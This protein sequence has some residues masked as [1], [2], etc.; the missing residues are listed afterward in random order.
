MA[1][2]IT[3][4]GFPNT[5]TSIQVPKVASPKKFIVNFRRPSSY[6]GEYGFDWM[7]DDYITNCE[8]YEKLKD[9]YTPVT[10][11]KNEYFVPWLSMFPNQ[12]NVKLKLEINQIE[13]SPTDIDIIKF[14]SKEGIKFEPN[15]IKVSEAN[16]K[17]ITIIC[18][19]PLS[20]DVAISLLDKDNNEVGKLNVFKNA[21]HD[22]LHFN[23]IPVRILRKNSQEIDI[24][25]IEEQIDFE[26]T[27][28]K[29]GVEEQV[30]GWGDEGRDLTADLTN[31]QN[32]LNKNSLNQALLQCNISEVYDIIIDESEWIEDDLIQ[33]EGNIFKDVDVLEK[34]DKEFKKQHPIQAKKRGLV[35]F[36][37]PL[38]KEEAGGE[39]EISELDA[40]RL[41]VY[42]SNLWDK[43][44]V[45]HEIAHVLG[46]T[47][48]FQTKS[49]EEDVYSMNQ[50]IIEV[51]K[52]L[53][54]MIKTESQEE[55]S[56]E[57][58]FYKDQYK[59]Y[60]RYLNT[61]YRNPYI[62]EEGATDNIMDYDNVRESFWKYQWEALHD[63][64]IKFYNEK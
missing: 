9:E 36:L 37:S 52:R 61:H 38:N 64:V 1:Q 33:D 30:K 54:S 5:S 25:I 51:D 43:T 62:F 45:A 14:P 15:E 48:S 4:K 58:N 32:Y 31:L 49:P 23:I 2:T 42:L 19:T 6:K 3:I 55:I 21:N 13:G 57:W 53:N 27:I 40:K 50:F 17:E 7:R 28:I 20:N 46:L 44:T 24:N 16:E 18:E 29:N 35:L 22:Q 34:F 60:R 56:K 41:V 59:S 11:H 12:E 8:D 39:G 47:H 10:I 63:D 26:G